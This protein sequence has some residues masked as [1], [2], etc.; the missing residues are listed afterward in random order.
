MRYLLDTNVVS[1][2]L[3][4]ASGPAAKRM[5][6]T[7][8]RDLIIPS[9]V[10]AELVFGA[11]KGG[12]EQRLR[13]LNTFLRSFSSLAFDDLCVT[14]YAEIRA[15]L[16]RSGEVIGTMDMLIAAIALVHDLTL[17]THNTKEFNRVPRLRVEDWQI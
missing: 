8:S 12:S 14:R 7:P 5:S 3:R 10:R 11:V 6:Q 13:S 1:S 16:E 9:I 4:S 17:V 2:A 15:S